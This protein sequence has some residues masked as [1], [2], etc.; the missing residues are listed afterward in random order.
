MAPLCSEKAPLGRGGGWRGSDAT[1][2]RSRMLIW[3]RCFPGSWMTIKLSLPPC[4]HRAESSDVR[5][6][7]AWSA[8]TKDDPSVARG[9]REA[10]WGVA[11]NCRPTRPNDRPCCD[12]GHLP[13]LEKKSHG[14]IVSWW[15]DC[16]SLFLAVTGL[17]W[18]TFNT[19]AVAI[20]LFFSVIVLIFPWTV[21][22]LKV[23]WSSSL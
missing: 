22:H 13:Y 23:G 21:K 3:T 16:S 7:D 15:T 14:F 18:Q 6:L 9:P 5:G 2:K 11:G 17:K 19:Q 20:Y 12:Y 8:P 10:A 1:W 4:N